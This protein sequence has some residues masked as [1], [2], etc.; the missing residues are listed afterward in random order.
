MKYVQLPYC[1]PWLVEAWESPLDQQGDHPCHFARVWLWFSL[2]VHVQSSIQP[3]FMSKVDDYFPAAILPLSTRYPSLSCSPAHNKDR[4]SGHD[5]LPRI[6][7]VRTT[8]DW[9]GVVGNRSGLRRWAWSEKRAEGMGN[10]CLIYFALRFPTMCCTEHL[11]NI[12]I[13]S[14]WINKSFLVIYA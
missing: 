6:P 12:L 5:P 8:R 10:R 3:P 7:K 11:Y 4:N 2:F 1:G 9:R 14:P 13:V